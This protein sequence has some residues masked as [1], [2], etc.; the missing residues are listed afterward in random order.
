MDTDIAYLRFSRRL[1]IRASG[2]RLK[3]KSFSAWRFVAG[4]AGENPRQR[5]ATKADL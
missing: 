5:F 4:N 1:R 3:L 2:R